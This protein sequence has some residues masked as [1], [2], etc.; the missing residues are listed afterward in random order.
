M[1]NPQVKGDLYW[2]PECK[3]YTQLL[4]VAHA[5]RLIEVHRRTIYRYI[6]DGSVYNVKTAHNKYRVCS[7]CLVKK[8]DC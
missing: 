1:T 6:E 5:A 3:E 4:K 8:S 7:N 2:C